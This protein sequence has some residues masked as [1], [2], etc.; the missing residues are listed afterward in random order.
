MDK[1][2]IKKYMDKN[3]IE[4]LVNSLG[5]IVK[6]VKDLNLIDKEYSQLALFSQSTGQ[7]I[8]CLDRYE[9]RFV[10]FSDWHNLEVELQFWIGRFQIGSKGPFIANPYLNCKTKEEMM[11]KADLFSRTDSLNEKWK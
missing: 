3:D 7:V 9:Y 10:R 4:K 8:Q 11:I 2:T 1:H 5:F 6:E